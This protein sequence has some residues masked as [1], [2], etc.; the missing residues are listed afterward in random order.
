MFK[1]NL[2]TYATILFVLSFMLIACSTDT[3]RTSGHSLVRT[4]WN[5][6]YGVNDQGLVSFNDGLNWFYDFETDEKLILCNL[7]DC[8]HE[9]FHHTRNP[10]PNCLA[11]HP[12]DGIVE[13]VGI[14]DNDV[15]MFVNEGFNNSVTYI[16]DLESNSRK[17]LTT[18]DWTLATTNTFLV[19]NDT[20]YFVARRWVLKEGEYSGTDMEYGLLSLDLKSGN[21]NQYGPVLTENYGSV[22]KFTKIGDK[23][24][25]YYYYLDYEGEYDFMADGGESNE[26]DRHFLYEI[27][28]DTNEMQA[29][30]NVYGTDATLFHFD[31]DHLYFLSEDQS[32]FIATDWDLTESEVLFIGEEID[33]SANLEEGFIYTQ[34]RNFDGQFYYYDLDSQETHAFTRPSDEISVH[35]AFDEWL[36]LY[37]NLA[38]NQADLVMIDR[39]D[40]F[41]GETNYIYIN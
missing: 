11:T 5:D 10:D 36:Y 26:Y 39:E 15:F 3:S 31:K 12:S 30:Q 7:P 18:F 37:A 33:I 6:P 17:K 32:E 35:L 1:R 21:V 4:G 13:A 27:D 14:Y 19:E 25:F 29:I 24:Y 8:P 41:A 38:N 2:I 23:L 40:Y 28:I 16:V 34:H 22:R 20:A 9:P